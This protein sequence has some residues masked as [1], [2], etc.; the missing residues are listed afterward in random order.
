MFILSNNKSPAGRLGVHVLE[1]KITTVEEL[2]RVLTNYKGISYVNYFLIVE[3]KLNVIFFE[4]ANLILHI[5]PTLNDEAYTSVT[6]YVL[7]TKIDYSIKLKLLYKNYRLINADEYTLLSELSEVRNFY[8]H[9]LYI[10]SQGIN[11]SMKKRSA[12]VRDYCSDDFSATDRIN[13][14]KEKCLEAYKILNRVELVF[15]MVTNPLFEFKIEVRKKI[16][17]ILTS[18]ESITDKE[19]FEIFR[20]PLIQK[21]IMK[22]GYTKDLIENYLK[23]VKYE[24]SNMWEKLKGNIIFEN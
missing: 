9:N 4:W 15:S 2:D 13:R 16:L 7:D 18:K 23:K 1:E 14:F 20:I 21:G 12:V 19:I 17:D 10:K 5:F 11:E 24:E 6:E 8:A 3:T 22:D